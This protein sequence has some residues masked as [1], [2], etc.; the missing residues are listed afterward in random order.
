LRDDGDTSKVKTLIIAEPG[1]THDGQLSNMLRLIDVAAECGADVFKSQWTS[2][3]QTMCD[4]RHAPEY[5]ESYLKLQYPIEWHSELGEHAAARGLQYAC[6][7][8]IPGDPALLAP[9]VDYLKVSSFEA[10]DD[11]LIEESIAT[12]VE[13]IVSHGMGGIADDLRVTNLYCVSAYPAPVESLNLGRMRDIGGRVFDGFSDHSH[14][15][16]VGA[17][18]VAAGASILETHFRLDDCDPSNKDYAVA[19]T[20]AEFKTYVQ[21]VRDCE[22]AMGDGVKRIMPAE[23]PM[24]RY[25]VTA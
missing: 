6:T 21:N 22:A 23:E 2:N 16:R 10:G 20:P 13:V 7:A 5:L 11:D 4:R 17:W 3:A 24:L 9:F 12:R 19:F 25:R 14:D 18:A 1:S 8:Y 15:V